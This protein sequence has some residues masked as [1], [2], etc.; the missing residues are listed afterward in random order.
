MISKVGGLR[1]NPALGSNQSRNVLPHNCLIFF[2]VIEKEV[3]CQ[4]Y[5]KEDVLILVSER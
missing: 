1:R 5:C 2:T 4:I 3:L